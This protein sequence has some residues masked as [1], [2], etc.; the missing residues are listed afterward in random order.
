MLGDEPAATLS[1]TAK[2]DLMAQLQDG[3][4]QGHVD[5]FNRFVFVLGHL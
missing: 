1:R 5:A 2:F 3:I 4:L